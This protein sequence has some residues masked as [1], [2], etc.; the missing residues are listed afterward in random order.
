MPL[1][2]PKEPMILIMNLCMQ[3]RPFAKGLK[4]HFYKIIIIMRQNV[5]VRITNY[6]CNEEYLQLCTRVRVFNKMANFDR[7]YGISGITYV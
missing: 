3:G 5:R 6:V 2:A 1:V 4:A 7:F